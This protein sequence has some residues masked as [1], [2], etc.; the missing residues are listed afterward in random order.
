MQDDASRKQSNPEDYFIVG[1][2]LS[3]TKCE[4]YLGVLVSADGTFRT[5]LHLVRGQT[6]SHE[7]SIQHLSGLI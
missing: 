3:G 7:S 6:I 2:K 5:D 4:R 1:K